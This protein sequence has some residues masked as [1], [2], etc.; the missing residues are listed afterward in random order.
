LCHLHPHV[1]LGLGRSTRLLEHLHL[2]LVAVDDE[3]VQQRVA[4]QVDHR[5]RGHAHPNDAG[6][7]R[8][9]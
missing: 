8:V 9:A 3:R 6:G 2:G 5:L 4:Q 7:Q 1:A